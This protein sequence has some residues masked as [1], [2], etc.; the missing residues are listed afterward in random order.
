MGPR[1][2]SPSCVTSP[3]GSTRRPSTSGWREPW[4]RWPP[5]VRCPPVLS[6]DLQARPTPAIEAIAYFCSA[7]LLANVAQHAQASRAFVSCAQ[8]GTWLRLVVRDD[9]CG[10]AQLSTVGSSSSGLAG[11]TDRVH[12]VDGRFEPDQPTR[13]AHRGHRRPPVVGLMVEALRS[14]SPRTRPSSGTGWS[15]CW[16]IG[17]SSSPGPSAT[18][19]AL[20]SSVAQFQPD[21]AVI[22]I[23]MPP[24]FTDEGLRLAL[25]LRRIAT[26]AWESC[27]SPSTSRPVTPP[28]CWLG[29]R[30]RHRLPPQGPGGRRQRLRRGPGAGGDRRNGIGPR[31]GDATDGGAPADRFALRA[32]R[33]VSVRS[34]A[35]WPKGDPT[36]PSPTP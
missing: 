15:S 6:V 5:G 31:S 23:R 14:P 3:G 27:S 7:E 21:V 13:G 32:H 4:P 35:S 29:R 17:A 8:Q 28:I 1:R 24:T 20:R 22:D 25:E 10:G 26:R 34:W 11:L 19:R 18:R 9:G 30:R 12:A 2:P 36:R 33:P 16:W